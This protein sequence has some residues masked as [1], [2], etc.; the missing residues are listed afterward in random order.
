MRLTSCWTHAYVRVVALVLSSLHQMLARLVVPLLVAAGLIFACSPRTQ[1]PV[2]SARA[3]M[4]APEGLTSHVIVDTTRGNVRFA[5]EVANDTRKRVEL[6]FPDGR[7][8]DF[9]VLDDNGREVW[10]WSAGRM[11]TQ[12]IQNRLL[13][14]HDSAVFVER[15]T[16]TTPGQYTLVA[17][18]NSANY[19]VTQR[20]EFALH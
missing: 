11:F 8:H 15:W 5:I 9:T 19:P 1:S 2:S 10:R 3:N 7:T 16:A 18:L 12:S 6:T 20:V 17:S 13:D 4:R 14:A